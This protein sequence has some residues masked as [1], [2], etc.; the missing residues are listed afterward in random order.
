MPV[1]HAKVSGIT[2][3][4][5]TTLVRPSDWNASHVVMVNLATETT[6]LLPITSLGTGT[7]NISQW[8]NDAG[9]LSSVSGNWTGT[10]DG[11]EGTYYLA[12]ANHTGTQLKATI[13]DFVEADYAHITGTETI[14]GA[15]LFTNAATKVVVNNSNA[16][17]QFA[18]EQ[19]GTGDASVQFLL[20]GIRAWVVGIDNSDSDKFKISA[21]ND[22]FASPLMSMTTAG[23]TTF[24]NTLTASNLSGTN[25]GDQTITLTGDAT[26]SGTGSFS[27]T[28]AA[29]NGVAYNAD[30]LVQ[31]ALLAGR[32]TPQQFAFGN[33]SGANTGYLTSTA[34]ATKGKYGLTS[35]LTS[36]FDE[37]NERLG[38]GVASPNEQLEIAKNFRLPAS[39]A[40]V[41]IIYSGAN[42]YIHNQGTQNFYA[43][44]GAG[45][46]SSTSSRNVG[47]G[48][49]ALKSIT[50]GND[51]VV[52]GSGAGSGITTGGQNFAL[53]Q[54][55]LEACTNGSRN[56]AIGNGAMLI[57]Q[58]GSHSIGIGDAALANEKF[59]SDTDVYNVAVGDSAGATITTGT[60]NTLLGGLANVSSAT[61]NNII[62]IGYNASVGTSNTGV[63]G[64]TGSNAVLMGVCAGISTA[65]AKFGGVIFD[66]FADAGNSTT[67]ETDLYSDTIP[68]NALNANGQKIIAEYG[69]VFVSS[70]TATR[71]IKIYFGGTAIFDTGALTL[72]LSSAWTAYTTIIR[73]SATV[74]R[75]MVSF[76]TEGAALSAYTAV[77]ELTG[78]TLSNT[79]V[80]KITGQAAGIGAATGDITA[81][82]G[83]VSWEPAA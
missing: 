13:S 38:L 1:V 2:D 81:K 41:G 45:N 44:A 66:H 53:G 19:S 28:V 63:L 12:R 4:A 49:Q 25:T 54:R 30:P 22:G 65:Y 9:Y 47:I 40:S 37:L 76:T 6:G 68:A 64:G 3:V 42:R 31:Y 62:A 15:K 77:G 69:G 58:R 10:F 60:K 39:T 16:N 73:V 11:Q 18:I 43:G 70:G 80:L 17:A 79:N 59:T 82:L 61:V 7:G 5:D 72:S 57:E 8:T 67:T 50:S 36:V 21:A 23:V 33:A 14:T 24:A 48:D 74:I 26:G 29:I 55:T 34:H 56:V 78:L 46:L 51:N 52:L 75:Y 32:P 35:A 20:T 83:T 71:E 27:T